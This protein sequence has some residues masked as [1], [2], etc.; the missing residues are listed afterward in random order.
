MSDCGRRP[1]AETCRAISVGNRV[2]QMHVERL[3]ATR[4]GDG[5]YADLVRTA[6]RLAPLRGVDATLAYATQSGVAELCD[7]VKN[8]DGWN[9]VP[10]RWL[11]GVDH[12]RSD[13][14]ALQHLQDLG[15]SQLRVHD[16]RYIVEQRRCSPRTSFHPK[17]Y[18]FHGENRT[19]IVVG[20]GNLSYTGLRRGV[21]AGALIGGSAV[22]EM[23]AVMEWF[24]DLWGVAAPLAQVVE[25]YVAE[26]G[27]PENRREPAPLDEDEVPRGASGRG[28]LSGAELRRLRVCEHLWIRAVTNRNRGQTRP[29][30]Q[31]M[32][33]RNSR[34]FFGFPAEE[35][36]PDT[37]IGYVAIRHDGGGRADCS[38]RFSNNRMDVL[39]LPI[40]GKG[41]PASYDEETL[42]FRRIGL[43]RFELVVGSARDA[44]RWKRE[45]EK[46][47]GSF[48]FNS[49]RTWG[50]Y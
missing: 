46:V 32:M 29:G 26:Y 50:V 45:S 3:R 12:C 36:E 9:A 2:E 25:K 7:I 30:N 42:H 39:T 48:R 28:N 49:G 8:I 47:G 4:P 43:R 23:R 6:A 35:V 10:K 1:S 13:P 16:G 18:M 5:R 40:P 37:L 17:L 27:R 38:L 24:D 14:P 11:V 22:G 20:S 33:K 21:E 19:E 34:V 15:K 31:L 44:R 41:G